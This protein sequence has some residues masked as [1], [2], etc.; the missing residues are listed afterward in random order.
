[1]Q[2]NDMF[3]NI[4]T[5]FLIS[6]GI[7]IVMFVAV[8]VLFTRFS[9][10]LLH[11]LVAALVI[12]GST[13]SGTVAVT[14]RNICHY[15]SSLEGTARDIAEQADAVQSV[16]GLDRYGISASDIVGGTAGGAVA[17]VKGKLRTTQTLSIMVMVVLNLLLLVFLANSG[18]KSSSCKRKNYAVEDDDL[19]G[20]E[21][22]SSIYDI[23]LD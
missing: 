16:Y 8:K 18:S 4:A 14:S 5:S 3:A 20:F 19:D 1:M 6:L 21:G 7:A 13:I 10:E 17:K 11:V 15:I 9:P 2:Q 23:D 12:A 22:E